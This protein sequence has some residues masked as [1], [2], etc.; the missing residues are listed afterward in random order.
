MM[1]AVLSECV[2]TGFR[3]SGVEHRPVNCD[4]LLC[5]DDF[6]FGPTP[7]PGLRG[8][9]SSGLEDGPAAAALASAAPSHPPYLSGSCQRGWVEQMWAQ[10]DGVH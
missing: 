10:V 6:C 4:R 8:R 2:Y 7:S 5:T 9:G 3:G 1:N